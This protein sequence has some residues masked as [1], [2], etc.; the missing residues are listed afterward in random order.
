MTAAAVPV[1]LPSDSA[2]VAGIP[3]IVTGVAVSHNRVRE[4]VSAEWSQIRDSE[5]STPRW[6]VLRTGQAFAAVK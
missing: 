4:D 5:F 6:R 2:V 3:G 1:I